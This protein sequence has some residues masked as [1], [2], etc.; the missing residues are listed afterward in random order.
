MSK[1]LDVIKTK[2][3]KLLGRKHKIDE[4]IKKLKL[5]E[6]EILKNEFYIVYEKS[7]LSYEEFIHKISKQ[8]EK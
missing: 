3:N 2:I 8:K 4:E 5:R 6:E 7:N 1:E